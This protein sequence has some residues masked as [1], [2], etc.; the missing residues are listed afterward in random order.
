MINVNFTD[1]GTWETDEHG[2]YIWSA[3]NGNKC[4]LHEYIQ[5]LQ[6]E[7]EAKNTLIT[8]LE[9]KKKELNQQI[10]KYV[11]LN[12][13]WVATGLKVLENGG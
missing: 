7:L 13:R 8:A 4:Y 3:T 10:D 12:V 11:K 6:A 5:A 9:S 2:F 1:P